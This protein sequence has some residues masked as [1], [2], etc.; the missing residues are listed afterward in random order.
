[1][2]KPKNRIL[3]GCVADDFTGASDAASFLRNAG[4]RTLLMNEIQKDFPVPE[5][6]DAVVIA[7]KSRTE[8]TDVA[9][10]S[11]LEAIKWLENQGT[12]KFYFKYCSTF[13]STKKG[14]IGPVADA[15]MEYL[16]KHAPSCVL[17]LP[18][19]GRIVRSGKL[20]VNGVPLD[21]S[22]MKK[23]SAYSYVGQPD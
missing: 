2:E 3:L 14:N 18:V 7:L 16:G 8:A 4:L 10:H 11:T 21:Q 9:V 23:S 22:P 1:M 19:N 17:P 6:T 15:I 12:E 20:Y 5:Q 13:D